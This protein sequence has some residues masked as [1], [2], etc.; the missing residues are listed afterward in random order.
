[1]DPEYFRYRRSRFGW[2]NPVPG[3]VR[4]DRALLYLKQ[5]LDAQV[6]E[7]EARKTKTLGD[8]GFYPIVRFRR[9]VFDI[10]SLGADPRLA[11]TVDSGLGGGLSTRTPRKDV[12]LVLRDLQ[13][14]LGSFQPAPEFLE[15]SLVDGAEDALLTPT[16][17][18]KSKMSSDL[19]S[20]SSVFVIMPFK[21]D[22]ND[23]WIGGIKRAAETAGFTPIRVDMINRSTNITDDIVAS[24]EKCHLAI[25]DV[26]DNNPNVM[27][28]L[29]YTLAK[30]KP[31][32]IISQSADFLP[33][34]IRNIRTIVYANSW[35]GIEDLKIR[36][37]EFLKEYSPRKTG[38]A[39]R[40]GRADQASEGKTK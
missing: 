32:I 21:A 31:N 23:V 38:G 28:E 25:V 35:T 6:R 40:G 16:A 8:A 30:G 19:A 33:F 34:D 14:A 15:G 36:L 12:L 1:M 5:R 18:Q 29:G 24:I 13:L 22:M 2:R 39:R 26:T 11:E 17:Q 3:I 7:L 4:T 37:Q 10:C 20:R 27:F 9:E